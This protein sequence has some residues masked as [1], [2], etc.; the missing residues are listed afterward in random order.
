M[1][2]IHCHHDMQAQG[3]KSLL[4]LDKSDLLQVFFLRAVFTAVGQSHTATSKKKKSVPWV[5]FYIG[6]G[7]RVYVVTHMYVHS[8]CTYTPVHMYMDMCVRLVALCTYL[9]VQAPTMTN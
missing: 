7:S 2:L 8:T 1:L 3:L 5:N 9:C 6:H 4:L